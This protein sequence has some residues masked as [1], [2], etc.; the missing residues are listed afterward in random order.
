[1]IIGSGI[2]LLGSLVLL[3]VAASARAFWIANWSL[4]GVGSACVVGFLAGLVRMA[5]SLFRQSQMRLHELMLVILACMTVATL[6]KLWVDSNS[7]RLTEGRLFLS[8][9]GFGVIFFVLGAGSVWG[10]SVCRRLAESETRTRLKY[11]GAGWLLA[12][13]AGAFPVFALF[14]VIFLLEGNLHAPDEVINTWMITG[15]LTPL[16]IPGIM[17][18]L[19]CRRARG[20]TFPVRRSGDEPDGDTASADT[21]SRYPSNE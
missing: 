21:N 16:G 13:G 9:M 4:I 12:I 11:I 7:G 2:V 8:I 20:I 10:W 3:F 6:F 18:E 19:R 17:L 5:G 15:G 14:S 1:L